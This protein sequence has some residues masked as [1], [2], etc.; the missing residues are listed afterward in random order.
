MGQLG[1]VHPYW[2]W[3]DYIWSKNVFNFCRLFSNIVSDLNV[4][5][6]EDPSVNF[7]NIDDKIREKHENHPSV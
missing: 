6:Y 3:W 4:P 5:L 2:G 7:E 1:K